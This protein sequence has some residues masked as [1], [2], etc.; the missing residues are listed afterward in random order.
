[1]KKIFIVLLSAILFTMT[2][3]GVSAFEQN[4]QEYTY[5]VRFLDT[6]GE[7]FLVDYTNETSYKMP[8][9]L[10]RAGYTFKGWKNSYTNTIYNKALGYVSWSGL[11]DTPSREG[12]LEFIPVWSSN[13]YILTFKYNGQVFTEE[14]KKGSSFEI[15]HLQATEE[16]T[17]FMGWRDV[18]TG[19]IYD[20][21][22]TYQPTKDQT[23]DAVF[24]NVIKFHVVDHDT[25]F[26]YTDE[27]GNFTFPSLRDEYLSESYILEGWSDGKNVYKVGDTYNCIL[28]LTYEFTAVL[29]IK[30]A[31]FKGAG[32]EAFSFDIDDS[33][34]IIFPTL[35]DGAKREGFIFE[36]WSDGEYIYKSGMKY[37]CYEKNHFIFEAVWQ[38]LYGGISPDGTDENGKNFIV[39]FFFDT[40]DDLK[41]LC[42]P[43]LNDFKI[44]FFDFTLADIL[45]FLF[46]AFISALLIY[47]VIALKGA[48]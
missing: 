43:Y 45:H 19:V 3:L 34:N 11:E 9:D 7:P 38:D 40:Y 2:I 4:G 37:N 36:G 29:R 47:I 31:T 32:F 10:E 44:P 25:L 13:P 48:L 28:E 41:E 42:S 14:V 35:P 33:G 30:A 17:I 21:G 1:M 15:P 20:S 24:V 12:F 27:N 6:N 16:H 22:E 18:S 46:F 8:D 23:F 5:Q 39:G 26:L